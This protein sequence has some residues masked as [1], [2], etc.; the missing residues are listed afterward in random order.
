MNKSSIAIV[1]LLALIGL[2]L[3]CPG[4]P[5]VKNL[6]N[7]RVGYGS[8]SRH[9]RCPSSKLIDHRQQPLTRAN[10]NGQWSLMFFGYTHCPDICPIG[11]QTMAEMI[12]AIDDS[13]VS[14]MLQV[15]FMSVDPERDRPESAGRIRRL[16]SI[17]GSM[18]PP[19]RS[20]S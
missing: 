7:S 12:K 20:S 13:D 5:T 1:A 10:L 18:A 2:A 4:T 8:A 15:Y 16:I 3:A 11:L 19:R 9:A 17:P 14:G 6:S